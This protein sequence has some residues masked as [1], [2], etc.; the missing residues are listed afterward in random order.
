VQ[1]LRRAG[2]RW[3]EIAALSGV[4][5]RT[6]RRVAAE[7]AIT[8]IDNAAE[9]TRRQVGRPSKADT[10]RD[11]LMH[12]LTEEPTLRSVE[13]LHRAR[14]AGYTGGKSAIYVLAQ[15]LRTRVVTPLVCF[16]GLPGEFC[17]HD[18][19]EVRVR[20]QHGTEEI[21]H[22]LGSPI[23][24]AQERQIGG[25]G[26][27]IFADRNFRGRSATLREDTPNL[28][29][30]GVNDAVSSLQVGPGEQWEVCEHANYQ[31]RCVVVS[32]SESDLRQ[33]GWNDMISSARRLRGGAVRPPTGPGPPSQT[34][35]YIV[36]FDQRNFREWQE[37]S[38]RIEAEVTQVSSDQLQLRL[39][40]VR[41]VKE[42]H[43][44]LA[45][46]PFVCPDARP[47]QATPTVLVQG[48]LV[49]VERLALPPSAVVRVDLRDTSRADAPA[50]SLVTQTIPAS[51]G[52]PFAFSLSV[53]STAIDPRASLS[54]YLPR[55]A[56]ARG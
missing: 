12:A 37:D 10:Y 17:Q 5:V 2:H 18:F 31:G 53:P 46:V 39:H 22:F 4:S 51:Q 8:T 54:R 42:E 55:S 3:K 47:S 7:T 24:L 1:V 41:E 27:T 14:Q 16:E 25:V 48:T 44:R 50:R 15:T 23:G 9:R 49:Y 38:A 33:S 20:Y 36:L 21:V 13:L 43:Y 40:L 34:D 52:P 19:G 30:I 56:T 11:L 32:G 26:L 45:P 35:W 29:A 28:Q 6:V